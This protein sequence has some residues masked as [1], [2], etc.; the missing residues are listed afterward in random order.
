MAGIRLESIPSN[1]WLV[2]EFCLWVVWRCEHHTI[3]QKEERKVSQN[4]NN[5]N[6][7]MEDILFQSRADIAKAKR[8]GE[9]P[10]MLFVLFLHSDQSWH[11]HCHNSSW[12]SVLVQNG[13]YCGTC[14]QF[15]LFEM[16]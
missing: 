6:Q 8:I 3:S 16:V 11:Q 13:Q 12:L 10:I 4:W 1:D 7:A 14:E 2:K 9:I 15:C 5:K